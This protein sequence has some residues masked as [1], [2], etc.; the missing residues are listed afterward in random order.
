[1][2]KNKLGIRLISTEFYDRDRLNGCINY[3][4]KYTDLIGNID[5]T[6]N[7]NNNEYFGIRLRIKNE[8]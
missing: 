4:D 3:I 8:K 5:I 6:R 1:M 2:L 7:V